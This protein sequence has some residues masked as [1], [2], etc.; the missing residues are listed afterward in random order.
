MDKSVNDI[1]ALIDNFNAELEKHLPALEK[2]VDRIISEKCTDNSTIEFLLD[3][4]LSLTILGVGD[5]LYI[6]LV[7]YYKTVDTEG[8]LFYWNRY[9]SQDE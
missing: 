5:A 8:A 1:K 6:K 2:E 9:D 7:D 4:L 3:N